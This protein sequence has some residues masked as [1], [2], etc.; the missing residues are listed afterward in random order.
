MNNIIKKTITALLGLVFIYN[1]ADSAD[2]GAKADDTTVLVT[3]YADLWNSNITVKAGETVKWYVNV[4]E[5]TEPKGCSATIKIPE[6]GLGT[7]SNTKEDEHITLVQGQNFIYEF[8]PEKEGDIL[9]SCWM[10]SGCHH[11]YI[12]V[13]ANGTYN[14]QKPADASNVYA[15][16]SGS[17]VEVSFTAPGAPDGAEI[18]GYKVLATDENGKRKKAVVKE[19]PAVFEGLDDKQ[20]YSFK[21][22]TLATSGDSAGENDFKLNAANGSETTQ[23]EP[24][25]QESSAESAQI[26]TET[27]TTTVASGNN[28]SSPKTGDHGVKTAE[29]VIGI[30]ILLCLSLS[31]RKHSQQG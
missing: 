6:L 18:T 22:I 23:P 3:E 5:G 14:V 2:I 26:Q 21:V 28:S 20:S 16:R 8:T 15:K 19:S 25:K 24:T 13:T 27:T 7:D 9:F 31:K 1:A 4:P 10:G 11:N 17:N 12:H 30:S 29:L